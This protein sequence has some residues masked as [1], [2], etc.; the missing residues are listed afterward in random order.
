ML[1]PRGLRGLRGPGAEEGK[2]AE[3]RRRSEE[4]GTVPDSVS[5]NKG[6]PEGE[7]L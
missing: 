1:G 6:R 5:N 3:R 2:E 4:L 7:R